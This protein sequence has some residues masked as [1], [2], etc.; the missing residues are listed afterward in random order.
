MLVKIDLYKPYLE[1]K[2]LEVSDEFYKKEST[3]LIDLERFEIVSFL[4]H[5]E[6]R[7]NEE[8]QRCS[9][10][11]DKSTENK[12]ILLIERIFVSDNLQVILS[13]GFD[14]IT[15]NKNH[16]SLTKLYQFLERVQKLDYL[17]KT[18]SYYIKER[19]NTL[20]AENELSIEKILGFKTDLE[21]I[22]IQCFGKNSSLKS[23]M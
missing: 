11:L 4:D 8:K 17:K 10:Y 14:K 6:R 13:N 2:L 16:S 12:L 21:N 7:V 3:Q 20:I 22:L 9:E 23:A 1:P 5:V 15:D 19:G 18:W